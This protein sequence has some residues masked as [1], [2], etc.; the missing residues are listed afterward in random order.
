M[1]SEYF[2]RLIEAIRDQDEKKQERIYRSLE[3]HGMDRRTAKL[4]ALDLMKER[5]G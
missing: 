2:D 5:N 3:K 4:V 1:L